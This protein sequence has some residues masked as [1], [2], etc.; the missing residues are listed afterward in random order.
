MELQ[1]WWGGNCRGCCP[2]C[3]LPAHR[4]RPHLWQRGWDWRGSAQVYRRRC[5]QEGGCFCHLKTVVSLTGFW[6]I[7]PFT[8]TDSMSRW[9]D[10]EF[11]CMINKQP[12]VIAWV[13]PRCPQQSRKSSC[14]FLHQWQALLEEPILLYNDIVLFNY[15][16]ISEWVLIMQAKTSSFVEELVYCY[17]CMCMID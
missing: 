3:R 15:V 11:L 17:I 16:I 2:A 1:A 8:G 4:L 6:Y 5:G 14:A 9:C 13:K 10:S 7:S 12:R